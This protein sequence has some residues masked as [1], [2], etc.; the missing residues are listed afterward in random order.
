M[1]AKGSIQ[2]ANHR[3]RHAFW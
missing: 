3:L 2:T 1:K